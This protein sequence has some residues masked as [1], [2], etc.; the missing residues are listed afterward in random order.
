KLQE[1][2]VQT[3]QS[4]KVTS[5][6]SFM[7]EPIEEDFESVIEEEPLKTPEK[8]FASQ[9]P[10][11]QIIQQQKNVVEMNSSMSGNI[12]ELIKL[13]KEKFEKPNDELERTKLLVDESFRERGKLLLQIEQLNNKIKELE[14]LNSQLQLKEKS[15]EQSHQNELERMKK[16]YEMKLK[17]IELK[18]KNEINEEQK[19]IELKFETQIQQLQ[20]TNEKLQ[21]ELKN[22]LEMNKF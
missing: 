7:E 10:P 22:I 16:E 1:E 18:H 17:E 5:P 20:L 11:P 3:I 12:E 8:N 4:P 6:T 13:F 21:Q 14:N 15:L 19:K 2:K 9:T